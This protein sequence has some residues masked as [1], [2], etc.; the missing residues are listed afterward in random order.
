MKQHDSLGFD[1]IT[2]V[3]IVPHSSFSFCIDLIALSLVGAPPYYFVSIFLPPVKP[4]FSQFT[5]LTWLNFI[6]LMPIANSFNLNMNLIVDE[7]NWI[8]SM[9]Y[10]HLRA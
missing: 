5:P 8:S 2:L 3:L 9:F 10:K 4:F 7:S 1:Q 6:C